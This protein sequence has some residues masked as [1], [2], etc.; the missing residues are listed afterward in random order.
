MKTFLSVLLILGSLSS[1]AQVAG[2]GEVYLAIKNLAKAHT[3]SINVQEIRN[4]VES[5]YN[6]VC[7]GKSR[8]L[9]PALNMIVVYK[10]RCTG[11]QTIDVVI[12]SSAEVANEAAKFTLK[13]YKVSFKSTGNK[14]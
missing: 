10:A 14:K 11:D 13:N 2:T 8:M 9:A 3:E 12:K 7:R 4:E 6:V 1:F 5:R